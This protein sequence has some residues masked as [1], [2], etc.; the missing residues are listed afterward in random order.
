M[1]LPLAST[2]DNLGDLLAN[3]A[4]ILRS[5]E[6]LRFNG[7]SASFAEVHDRS[8]GI[9]RALLSAGLTPGDRVA[10]ALPNGLDWPIVWLAIAK[11]GCVTVPI[12]IAYER[13]D[14]VYAMRDSGAKLIVTEPA[15]L[16]KM[17][18]AR[19][20]AKGDWQ[21]ATLEPSNADLILAEEA[22]GALPRVKRDM[23]LN[24][25]YTSGTTGFP[26]GC[27][28]THDYWLTLGERSAQLNGAGR[29]DVNLTAQ[30]F[31]YADPQW[32]TVLSLVAGIP[33]VILPR[34][35][36]STFWQSVR[37]EGATVFYCVGTMPIMLF[38]QPADPVLDKQH[39]ARMIYCSGIP[40]KMHKAFEERWGVPWREAFGMTETGV[41]L[42][43]PMDDAASTASGVLGQ[44]VK[45]KEI[46]IRDPHGR[47]VP[48]GIT[49]ELCVKGKP[50]MLGYWNK[51]DITAQTIV[52]GWLH[53]GDLVT[54]DEAGAIRLVGRL[55]D[56]IRR[57]G[58]N[59]A[60]SEVEL[61]LC[62]HPDVAGAAVVAVP[63]PVRGEEVKAFI[64]PKSG[65][66]NPRAIL[67]HL[68]GRIA[69]FKHPR[70][71]AEVS[72]FPRTASERIEKHRLTQSA[73]P[74]VIR[75]YDAV[76][77]EWR[78]GATT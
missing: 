39:K 57:G 6:F 16:A 71:F 17:I 27:M 11:A 72:D 42:A 70:Y 21:I 9:A 2:F 49:G 13:I 32:N 63:D 77:R 22:D 41:D 30:P 56:M 66:F 1:N 20:F 8:R 54:M 38:N 62:E 37:S 35:S 7:Q 12:N 36:A 69:S 78:E 68:N 53:T 5:K 64:L 28:L 60:A 25:Q 29:G 46:A 50:M 24:L 15:L 19:S 4:K 3:R 44:P 75:H 33:L 40:P 23:L 18:D 59:I 48:I 73:N 51:P 43:V 67:E 52:D 61:V 45:G 47:D 14:H 26:K 55:K 58:E 76:T 74:F 65:E 10:I 31:H 34:F